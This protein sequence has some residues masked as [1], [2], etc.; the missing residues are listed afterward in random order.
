MRRE[1]AEE[2]SPSPEVRGEELE[3][4]VRVE[5]DL[6]RVVSEEEGRVTEEW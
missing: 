1:G 2:R 3:V 6:E 5:E 4:V